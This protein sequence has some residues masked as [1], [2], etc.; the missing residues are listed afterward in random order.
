MKILAV[1]TTRKSA[2]IF[3]IT[4]EFNIIRTLKDD[5]KQSEFLMTNIDDVLKENSLDLADFDVFGCVTGPGSFTGIRV[6]IATIKGFSY[7]LSKN[8]IGVNVFDI[9][10]DVVGNGTFLTECTSSSCYF[11]DMKNGQIVSTGVI[12]KAE[13]GNFKNIFVLKDEH[14]LDKYAYTLNVLEDYSSLCI[15]KFKELSKAKKNMDLEPYYIQ[16]SQAER[17]LE[18]K[19][20]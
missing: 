6:G 13:A 20:D 4:E 14:F 2:S 5:E 8:A 7:G 9:V 12:D 1:D 19:N 15:A 16:L 10:K 17:N 3:L 18:N 11:A